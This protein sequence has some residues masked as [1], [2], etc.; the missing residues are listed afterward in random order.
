MTESKYGLYYLQYKPPLLVRR[1]TQVAVDK[2]AL[3]GGLGSPS[4]ALSLGG[5]RIRSMKC[6]A[7]ERGM[8]S[9]QA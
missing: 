4:E 8:G 5:S 6:T 7:M 1:K 3:S 2:D 9:L